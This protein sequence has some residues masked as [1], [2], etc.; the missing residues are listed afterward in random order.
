MTVS[1]EDVTGLVTTLD[2]LTLPPGQRELLDAILKVVA[3]IQEGLNGQAFTG[4]FNDS[5]TKKHADLVMEYIT[6]P[7]ENESIK[8]IFEAGSAIIRNPNAV[9]PGIIKPSGLIEG[10]PAII[11]DAPHDEN[12][13]QP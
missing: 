12:D 7:P 10:P 4:E 13:E 3:D 9:P 1:E 5:F 6:P 8:G 11:R 2:G